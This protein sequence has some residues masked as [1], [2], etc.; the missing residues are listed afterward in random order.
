MDC[1]KLKEIYYRSCNYA[2]SKKLQHPTIFDIQISYYK[3]SVQTNADANC[4]KS[5][6]LLNSFKCNDSNFSLHLSL[7]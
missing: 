5:I 7:N 6:E 1:E 4:L 3:N 2:E